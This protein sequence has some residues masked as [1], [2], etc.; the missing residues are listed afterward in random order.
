MK[1]LTLTGSPWSYHGPTL[2]RKFLL[3]AC[4]M[5]WELGY[6]HCHFLWKSLGISMLS[7]RMKVMGLLPSFLSLLSTV[8]VSLPSPRGVS[9]GPLASSTPSFKTTQSHCSRGSDSCLFGS[10]SR[11]VGEERASWAVLAT[12]LTMSSKHIKFRG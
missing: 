12:H 1:R 5:A 4:S 6:L 3:S 2:F 7:C 8:T 10:V 9:L 11:G